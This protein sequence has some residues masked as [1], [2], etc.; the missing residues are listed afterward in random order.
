MHLIST[1]LIR[2]QRKSSHS[3][4][5]KLSHIVFFCVCLSLSVSSAHRFEMIFDLDESLKCKFNIIFFAFVPF[6]LRSIYSLCDGRSFWFVLAF[7]AKW[8]C[9][10]C[11]KSKEEEEMVESFKWIRIC[12]KQT[13][14]MI[15]R[16]VIDSWKKN[17]THANIIIV[18]KIGT[19]FNSIR[20]SRSDLDL[21]CCLAFW[22]KK[23]R[24]QVF[25]IN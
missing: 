15:V 24:V 6:L 19:F 21:K 13:A 9:E 11:K 8:K 25:N 22:K 16:F 3:F 12:L 18:K 14:V 20:I 7:A 10:C 1:C 2:T 23:K 4:S 17:K 5:W